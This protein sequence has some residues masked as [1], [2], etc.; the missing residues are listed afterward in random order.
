M[1]DTGKRGGELLPSGWLSEADKQ[2][3]KDGVFA[4][5]EGGGALCPEQGAC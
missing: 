5:T 2:W 3:Q 4:E 1:W